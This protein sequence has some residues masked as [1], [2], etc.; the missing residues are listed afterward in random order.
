[1]NIFC[2]LQADIGYKKSLTCSH[3]CVVEILSGQGN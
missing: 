3:F 2:L 1:V